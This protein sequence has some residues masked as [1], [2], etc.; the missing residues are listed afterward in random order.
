MKRPIF[1]VSILLLGLT[2]AFATVSQQR[3]TQRQTQPKASQPKPA[4]K[5]AQQIATTKDGKTVILKDDGTWEYVKEAPR[6]EA[7]QLEQKE[8]LPVQPHQQTSP[9]N[10]N[11]EEPKPWREQVR[12]TPLSYEEWRAFVKGQKVVLLTESDTREGLDKHARPYRVEEKYDPAEYEKERQLDLD[13]LNRI[14]LERYASSYAQQ[15]IPLSEY[16]ARYAGKTGTVLDARARFFKTRP[17]FSGGFRSE[18]IVQIDD[19]GEKLAVLGLVRFPAELEI[20]RGYV[21]RMVWAQGSIEVQGSY[22]QWPRSGTS[23]FR[24]ANTARMTVSRADWDSPFSSRIYMCFKTDDGREGCVDDNGCFD[25]RF[26]REE[27]THLF[28]MYWRHAVNFYYS[29]PKKAHPGWPKHVWNLIEQSEV[30]IGMTQEMA[31]VA[32]GG[33][34]QRGAILS[35]RGSGFIFEGCG[36]KF[37]VDGGKVVKYVE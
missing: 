1:L 20:A 30:A 16:N 37:L 25:A 9:P 3:K 4:T 24:V 26:W 27:C 29:D 2:A 17:V 8:T 34:G 22:G 21:G 14:G 35:D 11:N 18:Y 28:D 15:G 31:K 7:G 12:K 10:R 13:V 33:L 32:C 6:K 19:S 5:P 23:R 36:R